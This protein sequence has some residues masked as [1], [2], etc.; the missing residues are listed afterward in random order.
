MIEQRPTTPILRNVA[1]HAMLNLIPFARAGRK[2]AEW[3]TNFTLTPETV[4][5][6]AN[7][8]GR[9]RW[10][11]ENEGFNVQKNG[12]YGLTH[13]YSQD[14]IAS[15]VFYL[16]LQIAH[17]LAQLIEASSLFRAA[18]PAGVGSARNLAQRLL[19]A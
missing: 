19:E 15:K 18:C 12:G 17:L 2:V 14:A 13:R 4:T 16:L 10:K 9:L 1:K 7:D 5:P 8:G 6:L 11:I 3:I